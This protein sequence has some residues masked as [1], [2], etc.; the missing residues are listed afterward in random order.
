[1]SIILKILIGLVLLVVAVVVVVF[2]AYLFIV[3]RNDRR[4]RKMKDDYFDERE[5]VHQAQK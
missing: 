5:K 3:V 2:L 1:M 4:W